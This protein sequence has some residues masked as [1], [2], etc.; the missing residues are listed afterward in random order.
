MGIRRVLGYI[1]SLF[2]YNEVDNNIRAEL[3]TATLKKGAIFY[4]GGI[5]LFLLTS[6]LLTTLSIAYLMMVYDATS[7]GALVVSAKPAI[8][9][10][11]VISSLIYYGLIT[12]PYLFLGS[13]LHQGIMFFLMRV[14]ARGRGTYA[15]Q[16]AMSSYITLALGLGM[17]F[18]VPVAIVS[19]I[20]PCFMLFF[21]L[22]YLLAAVYLAL[23]VQAKVLTAVHKVSFPSAFAV[24][25]VVSLGSVVA[26]ILLQLIVGKFGLFPDFTATYAIANMGNMSVPDLSGISLPSVPANATDAGNA[27]ALDLTNISNTT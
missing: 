25:L 21:L 7:A 19:L 15:Q 12:L 1:V 5:F 14:I 26:Y 10:G 27:T 24:A 23:F 2:D 8:T 20:L 9:E 13:F 4:F 11:F 6:F 3:R 18:M 17:L 22:V 16:Y